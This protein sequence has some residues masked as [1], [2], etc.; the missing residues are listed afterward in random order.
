MASCAENSRRLQSPA[1]KQANNDD[2]IAFL[3]MAIAAAQ[4]R[5]G[6]ALSEAGSMRALGWRFALLAFLALPSPADADESLILPNG[7]LGM[8]LCARILTRNQA[9][10]A[11]PVPN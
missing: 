4:G 10:E 2:A 7:G 1:V 3:A 9:C 11:G 6:A 5:G 8:P